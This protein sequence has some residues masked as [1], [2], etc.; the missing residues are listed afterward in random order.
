MSK[1]LLGDEDFNQKCLPLLRNL[2][3]DASSIR[4]L[5]LAGQYYQDEEVLKKGI[6]LNRIV[7][8]HNW[9]HFRNL[10]VQY[11]THPGIVACFQSADAE[12]LANRVHLY[13]SS[14]D[15]CRNTYHKVAR[16]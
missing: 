15:D 13:L 2:V 14:L 7:L 8:T 3:Y 6:E 1:L 10:H 16:G 4:E 12:F 9:R 5:G 11:K